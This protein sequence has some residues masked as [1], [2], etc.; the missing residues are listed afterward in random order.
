V[1]LSSA[2]GWAGTILAGLAAGH[3]ERTGRDE[4]GKARNPLHELVAFVAPF[5]FIAALLIGVATLLDLIIQTNT[6]GLTWPDLRPGDDGRTVALVSLAVLGVC[7]GLVMLLG[8]RTD[9]NV[10][11]L[12][13]FYRNRLV[14][15]YLGATRLTNAKSPAADPPTDIDAARERPFVIPSSCP[16]GGQPW[17]SPDVTP[18]AFPVQPWRDYPLAC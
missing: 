4:T 6:G 12:N 13:A 15:A 8:W 3:S 1:S 18:S 5:L 11:S 9:I 16:R 17:P 2:A 7:A 10:F 14:R